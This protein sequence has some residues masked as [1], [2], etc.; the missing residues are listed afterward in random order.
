VVCN[1]PTAN[2]VPRASRVGGYEHVNGGHST[3]GRIVRRT[4]RTFVSVARD[5]RVSDLLQ[6]AKNLR[7]PDD[8]RR[9]AEVGV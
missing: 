5:A 1:S 3:I 7:I 9:D 8:D 2:G 4:D 6:S